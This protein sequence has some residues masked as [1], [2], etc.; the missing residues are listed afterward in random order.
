M[1]GANT[2]DTSSSSYLEVHPYSLVSDATV[3]SWLPYVFTAAPDDSIEEEAEKFQAPADWIPP[4][5]TQYLRYS[6]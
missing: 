6:T 4:T 2:S 1:V 3:A 5:E